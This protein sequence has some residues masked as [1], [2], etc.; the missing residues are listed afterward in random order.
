[1]GIGKGQGAGGGI[2]GRDEIK[3]KRKNELPK[4][5]G[6]TILCFVGPPGV[7]KTSLGKSIARALDRKIYPLAWVVFVTKAEIR[8]H[9]RTYVGV[10]LPGRII[11]GLRMPVPIIRC[12][13]LM[14]LIR[15]GLIFGVRSRRRLIEALD[16]EQNKEFSD[17]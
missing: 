14:K 13:C 16:P 9:R 11:Q 8:G 10:L 3:R 15:L 7:G 1:M 6:T 17:H 5:E 2:F 4:A 12:L